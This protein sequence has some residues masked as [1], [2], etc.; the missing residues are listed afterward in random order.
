MFLPPDSAPS[1]EDLKLQEDGKLEI[2]YGSNGKE[3]RIYRSASWSENGLDY[4]L[5]SVDGLSCEEMAGMAKE[6]IDVK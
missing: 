5:A 2:S 3:R 4:E 6:I 1:E